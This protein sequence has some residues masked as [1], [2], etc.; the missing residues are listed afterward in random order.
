MKTEKQLNRWKKETLVK[1][2]LSLESKLERAE[3][4]IENL[5]YQ[6]EKQVDD[7][8]VEI[9]DKSLQIEGLFASIEKKDHDIREYQCYIN[10]ISESLKTLNDAISYFQ[11]LV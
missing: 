5:K 11:N 3:N 7:F 9:S 2:V 6:H 8:L 10:R 1:R 4:L